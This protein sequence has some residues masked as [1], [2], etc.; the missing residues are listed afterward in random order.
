MLS[1]EREEPHIATVD[2]P[3]QLVTLT[4]STFKTQVLDAQGP[5]AV[6]FMSYGCTHCRT[7]EPVMQEVAT[8]V[9]AT[10]TMYR[11][12][13]GIEQDLATQFAIDGTPTLI[14]FLNGNEVA[15]VEGPHPTVASV[16][17]AVTKPFAS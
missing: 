3:Q 2:E 14:M 8:M 11:V 15:R 17:A 5:I 1:E 16:L 7:I 12:N 13:I 9:K 4:A 10:I 6:E